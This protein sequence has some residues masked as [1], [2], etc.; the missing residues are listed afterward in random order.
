MLAIQRVLRS[1]RLNTNDGMP[2]FPYVRSQVSCRVDE[3]ILQMLHA[4]AQDSNNV[5]VIVSG[6][7]TAKLCSAFLPMLDQSNVW[8][9]AENGAFMRP[10]RLLWDMF[11]VSE[12]SEWICLY[13]NLNFSW[14]KS[15]EQARPRTLLR[16]V[17]LLCCGHGCRMLTRCGAGVRVLLSAHTA[18]RGGDTRDKRGVELQAR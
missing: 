4:L 15:V 2:R 12:G 13:E 5:V 17:S 14:V 16:S 18:Q 9:A 11:S 1:I 10:P 6:A 3:H 8:L 7:T